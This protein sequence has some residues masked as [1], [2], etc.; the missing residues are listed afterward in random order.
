[1]M[2]GLT[3]VAG[4]L[5]LGTLAWNDPASWRP[6]TLACLAITAVSIYIILSRRRPDPEISAT[7][8]LPA[9]SSYA[10]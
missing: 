7:T 8:P 9:S 6:Y 5:L 4:P 2:A 3:T 1:M 10:P